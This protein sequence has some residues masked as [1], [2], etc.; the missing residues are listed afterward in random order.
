MRSGAVWDNVVGPLLG[1]LGRVGRGRAEDGKWNSS[2]FMALLCLS[3][4]TSAA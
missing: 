3:V 4:E 2:L 1:V